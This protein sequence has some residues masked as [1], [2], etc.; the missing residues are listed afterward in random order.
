MENKQRNSTTQRSIF[1][2]I[3]DKL[4]E[5]LKNGMFGYFFTSYDTANESYQK[6]VKRKNAVHSAAKAKRGV[7]KLIEKNILINLFPKIAEFLLRVSLRDYGLMM[8]TMGFISAIL[9]PVRQNILLLD[10][11]LEL[12]VS[13]IAILVCAIPLLFSSRSLSS[14]LY[15]SKLCNKILFSLLGYDEEKMREVAEKPK[16]SSTNIAFFAGLTLGILSYIV[17]PLK[18]IGIC[19]LAVLAYSTFRAPEIG[20]VVILAALPFVNSL[21]IC[22]CVV[23]VFFCY[24]I[25]YIIGKRTFKFEYFDLYV[26]LVAVYYTVRAFISTDIYSTVKESAVCISMMLAYFL[27]INLIR[28][29]EWFRRCVAMLTASATTVAI[30]AIAQEIVG[31][32]NNRFPE[33]FPTFTDPESVY[34]TFGSSEVLGHFLVALIPFTLVHMISERKGAKKFL[35]FILCI[36]LVSALILTDSL[37]AVVGVI[38][39][40][41]LLL[42]IYGKNN[43]YLAFVVCSAFPVLYLTLP[44]DIMN[45]ILSIKMLQNV[46]VSGFFDDIRHSFQL[47]M[48][49]PFGIGMGKQVFENAFGANEAPARSLIVQVLIEHGIIGALILGAF[50]VM[51]VRFVFSYCV[52]AKNR[53]RKINCCAGFCSI[54][55]LLNAGL[56]SYTMH[57]LRLFLLIWIFVALIVSYVRIERAEEEP[58]SMVARVTSASL[59][60]TLTKENEQNEAPRRKYVRAPRTMKRELDED[61]DDLAKEFDE[62]DE[63]DEATELESPLEIEKFDSKTD[64]PKDFEEQENILPIEEIPMEVEMTRNEEEGGDDKEDEE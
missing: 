25:K 29:K 15:N 17:P 23:F 64:D 58:K 42:V 62:F 45:R 32:L 18:I 60:I 19:A 56:I 37:S 4:F 61:D 33:V 10:I 54:A 44:D 7:S 50:F 28:S 24:M 6:K 49:K 40:I 27:F 13:G 41:L 22:I 36:V 63:D 12:F 57:D 14:N 43:I 20:A 53:Y 2:K 39:A 59:D 9:Y 35:G 16:W 34:A 47:F 1:G 48:S 31:K 11:S 3:S 46:S 38:L 8:I 26:L 51:L 21:V 5:L 52:K 55:G 30:F